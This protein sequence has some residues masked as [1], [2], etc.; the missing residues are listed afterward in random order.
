MDH[1][2]VVVAVLR[3]A[4]QL[5]AVACVAFFAVGKGSARCNLLCEMARDDA[6]RDDVRRARGVDAATTM[7][8]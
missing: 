5:S 1:D 3:E 8:R 4:V 2:D 6:T 7:T